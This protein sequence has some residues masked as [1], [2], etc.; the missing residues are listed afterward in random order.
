MIAF[1][2]AKINLGL[3]IVRRR[4]DGYHDLRTIFYP[5]GL[6][7]G[8]PENP[9]AFCDIL[10]IVP[11]TSNSRFSFITTGRAVDCPVEKNLVW[12]A[13]DL[14]FK[15]FAHPDLSVDIHLEKHLPDGAGMGGGSA[16]AAFTLRLLRELDQPPLPDDETLARAALELGADCPFFILNRPA[17]AEG[18]GECLSPID[19]NLAGKW[20]AVAKPDVF[21]STR[22]AFA[23]VSPAM[24]EFDLRSLPSIPMERW[25]EILVNDFE[26]SIFPIHPNLE[27][28]KEE[29]YRLNA[30]YAS[31]TGS[32]S[33]IYAIFDD[34]DLAKV[35]LQILDARPDII[36]TYLL[37]A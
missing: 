26:K 3:Q 2:N 34:E 25:R 22:E 11:V 12:R 29:F 24:P 37:K 14:Y 20:I 30:I 23:G 13:A 6:Y 27:M 16:D 19:I 8:Q 28:I 9:V 15:R 32:G 10:E 36:S 4:E 1:V 5:V 17:Y 35:A 7:A 33:C 31:L 18:V 21:V